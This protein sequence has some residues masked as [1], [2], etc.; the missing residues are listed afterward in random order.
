MALEKEGKQKLIGEFRI[1]DKDV[2]SPEVQI[3]MLTKRVQQLSGHLQAAPK[4]MHS[5]RG[6]LSMVARRK[7]L[8]GYLRNVSPERYKNLIDK[9]GLKK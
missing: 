9:L 6:L 3:A 7:K 4:D 5:K 8:L 2:G 1:H